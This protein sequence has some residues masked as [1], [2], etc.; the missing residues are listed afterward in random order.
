MYCLCF[1]SPKERET[2][3]SPLILYWVPLLKMRP[4]FDMIYATYDCWDKSCSLV[5]ETTDPSSFLTPKSLESPTLAAIISVS[6]TTASKT[7][8][9]LS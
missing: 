9:P 5:R 4:P 7:V 1:L 8:D 3:S 6:V 2:L